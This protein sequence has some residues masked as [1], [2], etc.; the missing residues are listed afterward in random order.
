MARRR[1]RWFT[2]HNIHL[3]RFPSSWMQSTSMEFSITWNTICRM[4]KRHKLCR[5][6]IRWGK[7]SLVACKD[8]QLMVRVRLEIQVQER[9]EAWF[10]FKGWTCK[11][12]ISRCKWW[13]I[14]VHQETIPDKQHQGCL[15]ELCRCQNNNRWCSPVCRL[16][17]NRGSRWETKWEIYSSLHRGLG[18]TTPT[19]QDKVLRKTTNQID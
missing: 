14:P 8:W 3:Q 12:T 4:D 7:R 11:C 10:R 15:K 19:T 5:C 2:I 16:W 6:R 9:W 18:R 17:I 13:E 1:H